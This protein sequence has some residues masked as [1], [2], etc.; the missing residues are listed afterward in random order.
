MAYPVKR[1]S[2]TNEGSGSANTFAN[3]LTVTQYG[4][5][6][7]IAAIS[8]QDSNHTNLPITA[9][10]WGG[11]GGQSFTKVGSIEHTSNVR[12]EIWILL[13]PDAG[14]KDLYIA[15]TGSV[16]KGVVLSHWSGAKQAVPALY[17]TAIGNSDTPS[18]DITTNTS[19]SV[20]IT[21]VSAEDGFSA[22]GAGQTGIGHDEGQPYEL[23]MSSYLQVATPQEAS[24]TEEI[25]GAAPW[26][27][28]VAQ[29]EPVTEISNEK[30]KTFL[31]KIY[32]S[33]GVYKKTLT[34]VIS[35]IRF[36]S[37]MNE[38]FSEL[39]VEVARNTVNFGEDI[40]VK[41]GN[42]IK[43]Y[44]FDSEN[45]DSGGT[46]IFS[47]RL[48]QYVPALRGREETV[49]MTFL[50]FWQQAQQ[51]I[52]EDD[53]ANYTLTPNPIHKD[54]NIVPE[55]EANNTPSTHTASASTELSGFSA[56]NAFDRNYQTKWTT[57]SSTTGWL[58]FDFG[59]FM[60]PIAKKY[61][62]TAP[63]DS[64][65]ECPK[66]WKFQG[67]NDG[68]SW[69]DLD[70]QTN[71]TS[72]VAGERKQFEIS[73]STAYRYY[74]IDV[75]A[76]NGH[77]SYL[78]VAALEIYEAYSRTGAIAIRYK[79]QDPS[80]ILKDLL[81]RFTQAG[82]GGILDYGT[83][84]AT[85]SATGTSV[86]IIFESISFQEAFRKVVD[87]CPA[88]WSLRVGADDKVYLSEKSS[89]ADHSFVLGKHIAEFIPEKR[90]ENIVNTLYFYGGEV[91]GERLFRKYTRSS[92]ISNY[93]VCGVRVA[94]DQVLDF[95]T[96]DIL[97]ERIL[98]NFDSPEIRVVLKIIDNNNEQGKGYD[99]ESIL[100][101]Q[102]CKIFNA[103]SQAENKWDQST[104]D[105]S[106]WD[107]D[108]TNAA[109][110]L[111]Q[112]QKIEY[113]PDY[114]ILELSNR[115][116]DIARRIEEIN[117]RVVEQLVKNSPVIPS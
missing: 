58:R 5:D 87:L 92:S 75:T 57:N 64:A 91:S 101:G 72:W 15:S 36:A 77:G 71:I 81:D 49:K 79:N 78:S 52:L 6:I 109:A 3:I 4:N 31:Y 53:G 24:L 34:D 74:R 115:Q 88:G 116:P 23:V 51:I 100:V 35:Q 18:V 61:A 55:M 108:I 54:E 1:A 38:G 40:D 66:T 85:I 67:S 22:Y 97:A 20:V 7:L 42:R 21:A 105:T 89:V 70:T 16:W 68:S 90:I 39:V 110:I 80:D 104:W 114:V 44:A 56:F 12:S 98:D 9:V 14:L 8:V 41:Y 19:E 117:K 86:E 69:T 94:N 33:S 47:G 30:K 11:S 10:R 99:I 107:F 62:I 48:T 63:K 28:I 65:T 112:I 45:G 13:N 2:G 17:A 60:S 26:A 82:F 113:N 29:I 102:T 37:V 25:G 27:I 32:S 106:K 93:G 103:T 46:L 96:M 83:S 76:N 50:S 84:P 111:L 73:N 43:V 95:A 59:V